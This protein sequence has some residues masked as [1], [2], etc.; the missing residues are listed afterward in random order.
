MGVTV[1]IMDETGSELVFTKTYKKAITAGELRVEVQKTALPG[2]ELLDQ[3]RLP[4]GRRLSPGDNIQDGVYTFYKDPDKAPDPYSQEDW[5]ELCCG[6][7]LADGDPN[8]MHELPEKLAATDIVGPQEVYVMDVEDLARELDLD[9]KEHY[10]MLHAFRQ[11]CTNYS[12]RYTRGELLQMSLRDVNAS[13]VAAAKHQVNSKCYGRP[14]SVSVWHDSHDAIKKVLED[15]PKTGKIF[16]QHMQPATRNGAGEAACDKMFDTVL[17]VL[18][19]LMRHRSIKERNEALHKVYQWVPQERPT[20]TD[21]QSQ[22]SDDSDEEDP[23]AAFTREKAMCEHDNSSMVYAMRRPKGLKTKMIYEMK[24]LE[25]LAML[26]LFTVEELILIYEGKLKLNASLR[27]NLIGTLCRVNYHA[28]LHGCEYAAFGTYTWTWIVRFE[29]ANK[30]QVAGPFKYDNRDPTLLQVLFALSVLA[31][32]EDKLAPW[33]PL[34][35]PSNPSS[36]QGSKQGSRQG[37]RRNSSA[38]NAGPSH[39]ARAGHQTSRQ[40]DGD[41]KRSRG[42]WDQSP[43]K[44]RRAA[45]DSTGSEELPDRE[46]LENLREAFQQA[47]QQ[48]SQQNQEEGVQKAMQEDLQQSSQQDLQQALQ[49]PPQ[50]AESADWGTVTAAARRIDF[51]LPLRTIG[52]GSRAK[53]YL[54]R[55][56]DHQVAVKWGHEDSNTAVVL[57]HEAGVFLAMQPLWGQHV[58]R[59]IAA[60]LDAMELAAILGTEYID[61][62]HLDPDG[63]GHLLQQLQDAVAAVHSCRVL[64]N[65]LRAGNVLVT[66]GPN[67]QQRV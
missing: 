19:L 29:A 52:Y 49:Q 13:T 3:L 18:S 39:A 25:S 21:S 14:E 37:S 42:Q 20:T 28:G 57:A 59:L 40:G 31:V 63:D 1:M 60:G 15:L 58:P 65:D 47:L 61:G 23:T 56:D 8:T 64:H 44:K 10:K 35:F 38:G 41:G 32:D 45:A 9:L 5:F 22:Y 17:E 46:Q 24:R 11:L 27:E 67:Q 7:V 34:D 30:L 26:A 54:H 50:P 6:H 55:L 4:F 66:E 53:V 43:V 48:T 33:K 51:R 36:R 62:R 12:D 2:L 16:R